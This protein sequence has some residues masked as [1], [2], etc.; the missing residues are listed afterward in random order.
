MKNPKSNERL[1]WVRPRTFQASLQ[2]PHAR[3]S[4]LSQSPSLDLPL[5]L[6]CTSNSARLSCRQQKLCCC[7]CNLHQSP[8]VPLGTCATCLAAP[9]PFTLLVCFLL[10]R[11]LPVAVGFPGGLPATSCWRRRQTSGW[12]CGSSRSFSLSSS[13]TSGGV[14]HSDTRTS[15]LDH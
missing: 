4:S 15:S 7:S 1:W 3:V 14:S 13:I 9:R 2:N 11:A 5:D 12:R 8:L 6:Q 10:V